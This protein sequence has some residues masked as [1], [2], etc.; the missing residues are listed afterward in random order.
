MNKK[1]VIVGGVAGGASTAARLRRMDEKADIVVMERGS[2]ISFANCGLPYYL[3]GVIQKRENLLVQTPE[4]MEA[5]FN[6][7]IKIRNEVMDIDRSNQE[8]IVKDL[9]KGERYKEKYDYLVLSPGADPVIPP[10]KGLKEENVF[11]LRDI[12]DTDQI[13]H[14]IS[15]NKPESAV[16]IGGGFI[17]LEMAE[18]LKSRNIEVSLVEMMDQVMNQM[19]YEMA[20]MIHNHMRAQ[21]VNLYLD[22]GLKE[23]RHTK[24]YSEVRLEDNTKIKTD[25]IFLSIGIKPNV[26]LAEKSGLEI[27][28]TGAIKVNEY[29]Q[30]S[31]SRI[32]AI[33]DAIEVT[34]IVTGKPSH[35]PLAG[36]ANKQGRIVAD[37]ICGGNK[38]FKGTQGTAIAKIFDLEIA[39]TGASEKSLKKAGID[40]LT[41][42]TNSNNHAGYYPGAVSMM[43]KLLFSPDSGKILGAQIVG[44]DKVDKN[45]DLLAAAVRNKMDIYDLQE[46]ESAYAP[47]FGSAK[48]PVNMAGFVAENILTEKMNVIYWNEINNINEETIIVDVRE[49]GETK[50]GKIEGSIN[51][52]LNRLRNNLDK[53]DK[54]K[55]IILYCAVGLRAYIGCRILKQNGFKKVKN[56][57]GGY[58][59]LQAVRDD[60]NEKIENP[61][62]DELSSASSPEEGKIIG[63]KITPQ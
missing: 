18:N 50:L 8:V 55:E 41:S 56:L 48:S 10:I 58:K 13:N 44:R 27:G 11:T 21:E 57:S 63:N 3:G 43:I 40:Y 47:P 9:E 34:D 28:D 25:M 59:L 19:D 30:T 46:L 62:Q 2:Y 35:I 6:I 17:G 29:L 32:Y 31:D 7:N 49:K 4:A 24:D 26:E 45:I 1:I 20:A 14:F 52:P 38:K 12:P 61:C 22:N 51:I 60:K 23:V 39:S 42:Y 37:N 54:D 15:Q 16:I 53:L 36:P 5:R 33:G